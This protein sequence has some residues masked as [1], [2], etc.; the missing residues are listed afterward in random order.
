MKDLRTSYFLLY[1]CLWVILCILVLFM[2]AHVKIT[3]NNNWTSLACLSMF[4][5]YVVWMDIYAKN[6]PLSLLPVFGYLI[7]YCII[8]WSSICEMLSVLWHGFIK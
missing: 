6:K 1:K 2:V 3:P 4:T 5:V 8:Y 7:G